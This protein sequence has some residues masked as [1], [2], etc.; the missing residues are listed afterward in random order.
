M[1]FAQEI[2]TMSRHV[3]RKGC[4]GAFVTLAVA[5]CGGGEAP[6]GDSAASAPASPPEVRFSARDFTFEGPRTIESGM[7]KLVLENDGETFHHLQLM[8]LPEG[9]TAEEFGTQIAALR[10][11]EALPDWV[12]PAGGV[13]PPDPGAEASV[14]LMV[15]P[16]E[17]AVTCFVDT[18]DHIPHFAKGMT[19]PLTVT[20]AATPPAPEPSTELTLTLVDYAFGFSTPP[21]AGRHVIRV[22]NA[23]PQPHEIGL[24]RILPGRSVD[25]FM[26]WA[27]TFEGEVPATSLGAVS[28]LGDGQVAYMDVDLAAGTYM[29][30]C[31]YPDSGDGRPHLEHGMML[32]FEVT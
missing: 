12:R 7:L 21:A 4:F 28:V 13:N 8:R 6:A 23:G 17:Y 30:L 10:P 32:T 22:E 3:I 31:F 25:D 5:A 14:T 1:R 26:Q 27:Q 20:P 15:E 11:G 9:M 18:P 16:G 24:F 19:V 2:S 29:A